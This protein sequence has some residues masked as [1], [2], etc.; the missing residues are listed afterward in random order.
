MSSKSIFPSTAEGMKHTHYGKGVYFTTIW[1]SEI[2]LS[3]DGGY[4]STRRIFND[5]TAHSIERMQY[6]IGVSID[7]SWEL[8]IARDPTNFFEIHDIW[9]VEDMGAP[10]NIQAQIIEHGTTV[11]HGA[12][13]QLEDQTTATRDYAYRLNR[14]QNVP[15]QQEQLWKRPKPSEYIFVGG[16]TVRRPHG[17]EDD[18]LH[19]EGYT[20][21]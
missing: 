12:V 21:N 3:G 13:A 19:L 8:L 7:E 14:Q 1:P 18:F 2:G 20:P 6:Y 15:V 11:I 16:H 4:E 9:V 5:V 10:L 17:N